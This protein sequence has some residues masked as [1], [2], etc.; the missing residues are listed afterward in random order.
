MKRFPSGARYQYQAEA[1]GVSVFI[2]HRRPG[3]PPDGIPPSLA[4]SSRIARGAGG[5]LSATGL[6]AV[7]WGRILILCE[8]RGL[9]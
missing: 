8:G 1:R 2:L 6:L 9:L 4:P 3:F 5:V 7:A